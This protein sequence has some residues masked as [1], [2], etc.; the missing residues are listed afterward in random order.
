[1][2]SVGG[3]GGAGG[4]ASRSDRGLP[5]PL[6]LQVSDDPGVVRLQPGLELV[7]VV[8]VVGGGGPLGPVDDVGALPGDDHE[9][10]HEPAHDLAHGLDEEAAEVVGRVVLAEHKL[11][12]LLRDGRGRGSA[13]V[14]K[15]DLILPCD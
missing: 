10:D 2:S 12:H 1:M 9:P 6:V 5:L 13:Q 3:G 15:V 14:P 7:E 11:D 8:V 4:A